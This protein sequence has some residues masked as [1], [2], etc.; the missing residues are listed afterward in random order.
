MDR[1]PADAVD[2]GIDKCMSHSYLTPLRRCINSRWDIQFG[3]LLAAD[4]FSA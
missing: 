2:F 1:A 4:H 3:Q